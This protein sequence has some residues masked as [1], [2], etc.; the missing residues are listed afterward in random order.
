MEKKMEVELE[1]GIMQSWFI[2]TV[3]FRIRLGFCDPQIWRELL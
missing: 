2:E 1:T 3:G